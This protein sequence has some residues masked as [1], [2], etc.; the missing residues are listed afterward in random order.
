MPI[1]GGHIGGSELVI[2]PMH[3]T[4]VMHGSGNEF[5]IIGD[6]DFKFLP[7]LVLNSMMPGDE[8]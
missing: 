6:E 4:P 2:N 8:G 5:A 7:H 3:G 1:F